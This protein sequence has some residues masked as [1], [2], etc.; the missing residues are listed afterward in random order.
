M[1]I[2]IHDHE[3]NQGHRILELDQYILCYP[4]GL[5]HSE[6]CQLLP[7]RGRDQW[8]FI[9]AVID[10]LGQDVHTSPPI[11]EC[12]MDFEGPQDARNH[13]D[14]WSDQSVSELV[15]DGIIADPGHVSFLPI[16]W[17]GLEFLFHSMLLTY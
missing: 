16:R 13:G 12:M 15:K 9:Q 11:A 17:L 8:V 6:I 5:H 1:R 7:L 2:R 4:V 10:H 14:C 3:I